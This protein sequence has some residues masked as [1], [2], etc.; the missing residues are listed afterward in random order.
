M[1]HCHGINAG[2]KETSAPC[3]TEGSAAALEADDIEDGDGLE[4]ALERQLADRLDVGQVLHRALHPAGDQD[5]AGARVA[6]EAEGQVG[7]GADRTVVPPALE[8]DGADRG[9]P[10]GD[11]DADVEVVAALAPPAL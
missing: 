9:V 10:L 5:L 1:P 6:A 3:R 4:E 8:A 7:D 2:A 11:P